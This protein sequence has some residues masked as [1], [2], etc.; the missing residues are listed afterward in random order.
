MPTVR[1]IGKVVRNGNSL[2]VSIP[3]PMLHRLRWLQGTRVLLEQ[4]DGCVIVAELD[5]AMEDRLLAR[6]DTSA[7]LVIEAKA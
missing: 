7:A 3:R 2:Q 4:R 5:R 6:L 1:S